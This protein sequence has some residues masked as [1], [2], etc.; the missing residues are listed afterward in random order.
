MIEAREMEKESPTGRLRVAVIGP[1]K[2]GKSCLTATTGGNTL[3]LDFDQRAEAVA[4]RKGVYAITL[5]DP[6]FPK[7][8]EVVEDVLD[9]MSGLEAS[10]DLSKLANSKT[11]I[12]L[13]PSVPVETMITGLSFDSMSSFAKCMMDYETYNNPDLCRKIK[14]GPTAEVRVAKNFDA[15]NAEMQGVSQVVMRAFALP[16]N[17][18][19]T[20]HEAAE[21]A[22]DSTQEKP[23]YTGRVSIYPVRYKSLLK[24]FNEVWR[25]RL[26]AVPDS[27]GVRYLPRV[28]PLPD[29]SMDAA[30][31][32]LL[33]PV[34]EPNIEAMI[35]KHKIRSGQTKALPTSG[36][37]AVTTVIAGVSK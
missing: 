11:G 37:Q 22:V 34:E 3:I 1:E 12:K 36:T 31:T 15:W 27:K 29:Y 16:I 24:Y 19:C 10:L 23:K 6:Q 9:I 17:V 28:Y 20:F 18:F 26:T 13:F 5:K 8:P 21:E 30:T 4:G 32:M 35:A 7:L 25:V 2:N 14:I 33:D